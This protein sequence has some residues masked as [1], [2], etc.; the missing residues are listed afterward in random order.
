MSDLSAVTDSEILAFCLAIE[1]RMGQYFTMHYSNLT[2]PTVRPDTGGRKYIR[3]VQEDPDS[4]DHRS[5][6][7]FVER[8]TG[9]IWKP[10]SWKAPTKNFSRGNIR[11]D[12]ALAR[13]TPGGCTV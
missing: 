8:S 12:N 5:V 4:G 3:I 9:L 6:V 11:E 1:T 10:A 7:C 2:C 13:I